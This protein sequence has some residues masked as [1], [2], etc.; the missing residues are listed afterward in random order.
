MTQTL[1]TPATLSSSP[2]MLPAFS[3]LVAA[4]NE[5]HIID[6]HVGS[7]VDLGAVHCELILCAG[8]QDGTYA[9]AKRYEDVHDNI[10]V[11]EQQPGQ[12]KQAA[13]RAMYPHARHDIIYLT[14]AD[15]L[16]DLNSLQHVL[17]PIVS[18]RA[19]V[20]SGASEPLVSQRHIPLVQY[21]WCRERYS[22][23][24]DGPIANGILGRN[25][26]VTRQRL[27]SVGAFSED[28]ATGTDYLLSKKLLADGAT[29]AAANTSRV[30]AE[31]PA[32]TSDYLAK[33]RRW[34][35][36]LAVH[37]LRAHLM[38]FAVITALAL[39]L[40]CAPLS[41]LLLGWW[42]APLLLLFAWALVRRYQWL[43]ENRSN[44]TA[45][46][47]LLAPLYLLLDQVAVLSAGLDLLSRQ[48]RRRW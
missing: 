21:Q 36:N 20:S 19:E 46:V 15:C 31:Y 25:G 47:Y 37:D 45:A 5:A 43:F 39:A 8:G 38:H 3:A 29:I 12:G 10:R 7:F 16:F 9:L 13:L 11:L 34:I 35:K 18:G 17:A 23:N 27:D 28:T 2:S 26:A 48:G 30:K 6:A 4:W 22:R 42:S 14:D 1:A 40:L 24:R 32:T 33:W 44:T 41:P